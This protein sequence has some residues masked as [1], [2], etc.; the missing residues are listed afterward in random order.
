MSA[1]LWGVIGV[2]GAMTSS[3]VVELMRV[4]RRRPPGPELPRSKAARP[5]DRGRRRDGPHDGWL[6]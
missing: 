2:T 4:H 1:L 3:L 5:T 6:S